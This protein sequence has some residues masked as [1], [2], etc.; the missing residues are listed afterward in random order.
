MSGPELWLAGGGA[1][2]DVIEPYAP[3]MFT[4]A[5]ANPGQNTVFLTKFRLGR[6]KTVTK[7][8]YFVGAANGNVDAGVYRFDGADYQLVGRSG[9]VA[10]AGTNTTQ[11]LTMLTPFDLAPGVDYWMAFATDSASLTVARNNATGSLTIA[12]Y[13]KRSIAKAAAWSTGLPATIS[14]PSGTSNIVWM[15]AS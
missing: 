3:I 10:A 5:S 9:S 13:N 14:T 6:A 11:E 7:I 12:A 15:A 8:A 1:D 2:F 4:T